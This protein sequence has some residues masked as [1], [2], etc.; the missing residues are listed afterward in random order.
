ML[1]D[2]ATGRPLDVGRTQYPFTP[3]IRRAIEVRDQHCTFPGCTAKPPWCHT[4]HLLPYSRGGTTA[5]GDGRCCVGGTT[6]SSTPTAGPPPSS[7]ATSS[8]DHPSTPTTT[9]TTTATATRDDD[10]QGGGE[11]NAHLQGFERELRVLATRWLTRHPPPRPTHPRH[12]ITVQGYQ[13][14]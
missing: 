7:T 4:H 5:E 8:G 14:G 2:D 3:A 12:P 11:S 10:G 9:P 1:L 6:A 13:R